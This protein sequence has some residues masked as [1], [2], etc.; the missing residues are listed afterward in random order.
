[1]AALAVLITSSLAALPMHQRSCVK[2]RKGA[3]VRPM[4]RRSKSYVDDE[5]LEA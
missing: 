3:S 5:E 4:L 1:V 2:L